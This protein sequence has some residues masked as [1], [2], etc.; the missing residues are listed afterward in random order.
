MSVLV[1]GA[2]GFIGKEL[3]ISNISSYVTRCT[4]HINPIDNFSGDIFPI[5]ELN[6]NTDWTGAFDNISTVIHLAGIAHKPKT[7]KQDYYNVN[8][9]GAKK[10]ALES[11]ISGVKKFIYI[12]SIKVSDRKHVDDQTKSQRLAEKEIL[13]VGAKFGMV[14][15]IIR[16][17]L[18]Y[19]VNPPANMGLL[20]KMVDKLPVLPFGTVMNKMNFISI[21]NLLDLIYYCVTSELADDKLLLCNDGKQVS[22]RFLTN[23]IAFSLGKSI[24]QIPI[25]VATLSFVLN[26]LGKSSVSEILL[27]NSLIEQNE[28]NL[29]DGWNPPFTMRDSMLKISKRN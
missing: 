18:V 27:G 5:S 26:F 22:I 11:A 16:S 4:M 15:V 28:F 12:S 20:F 9:K 29:L 25:S 14:V 1:T 19:G 21:Y 6:E 17:S 13:E 24:F 8:T 10:L 7:K 23:E 3:L 2:S